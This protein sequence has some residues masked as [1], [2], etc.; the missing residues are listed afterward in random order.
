[1]RTPI[2]RTLILATI[3]ICTFHQRY[4][5]YGKHCQVIFLQGKSD[6]LIFDPY[7]QVCTARPKPTFKMSTRQA[8]SEVDELLNLQPKRK[9]VDPSQW[10]VAAPCTSEQFKTRRQQDKPTAREWNRE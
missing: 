10:A 8:S 4:L 7:S 9:A 2:S 3:Y 6:R 5:I 1:M